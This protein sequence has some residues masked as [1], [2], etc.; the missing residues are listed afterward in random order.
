MTEAHRRNAEQ[1]IDHLRGD[2]GVRESALTDLRRI[3]LLGLSKAL[4]S[5]N[6]DEAFLEDVVQDTLVKI[7]D[8]LDQFQFRSKFTTWAMTI[9][10][11]EAITEL[12]R[13]RWKDVSLDDVSDGG[14]FEPPNPADDDQ[15][16]GHA[17]RTELVASLKRLVDGRLT[18]KQRVAINAE[19]S[20]M[21]QEEIARRTDSNRN[22]IYKL[23]HDARKKLQTGLREEG[24]DTR[25]V[26]QIIA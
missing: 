2:S 13:L 18:D 17:A 9:A 5:R 8:R 14:R 11:R 23:V 22:A 7:L 21:P 15:P 6:L 19:L 26:I 16:E 25:E 20:G 12:R 3:L 10:T 1:W 24:Y 4:R